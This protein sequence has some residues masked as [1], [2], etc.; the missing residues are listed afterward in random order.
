MSEVAER[1]E[2]VDSLLLKA[3][4]DILD[5]V[6][7]DI[8]A[9]ARILIADIRDEPAFSLG[10]L[11]AATDRVDRLLAQQ[12]TPDADDALGYALWSWRMRDAEIP[13]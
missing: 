4:P 7:A 8:V 11:A 12:A 2:L 6:A 3:H 1:I 10:D 5:A 9:A 13:F